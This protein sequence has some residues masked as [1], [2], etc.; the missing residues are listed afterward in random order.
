LS[1]IITS[2]FRFAQAKSFIDSFTSN[3]I[4][5]AIGKASPWTTGDGGGVDENTPAVPV[6]TSTQD[7]KDFGQ[8]LGMKLIPTSGVSYV[9][10]RQDWVTGTVYTMYDDL[11]ATVNTAGHYIYV[12]NP[13]TFG[14]YKCIWNN[15]GSASTIIPSGN[16][17]S[18]FTTADN[19]QWKYMFTILPTDIVVFLNSNWIPV[20]DKSASTLAT[21]QLA[22]ETAAINGG[23]HAI[24]ITTGGTGYT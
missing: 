19:Y 14:V 3:N 5:I 8:I 16:S 17:T 9:A 24:K 13:S 15:N 4:Y 6:D 21:D 2:K 11:D 20:R 1:A 12:L 10:P 18:I 23:V 7:T 22:V